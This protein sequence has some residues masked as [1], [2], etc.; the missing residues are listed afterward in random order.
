MSVDDLLNRL[1]IKVVEKVIELQQKDENHELLDLI[2]EGQIAMP[3]LYEMYNLNYNKRNSNKK[4]Y[5]RYVLHK[6]KNDL[7]MAI[8]KY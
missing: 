1:K 8:R 6:Y 7:E 4:L 5:D 2:E 3:Q